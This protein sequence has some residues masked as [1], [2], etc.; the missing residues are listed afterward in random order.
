MKT[1]KIGCIC[2]KY[3][4]LQYLFCKNPRKNQL[5]HGKYL[6]L[7]I[8]H[9]IPA[10]GFTSFSQLFYWHLKFADWF[11]RSHVKEIRKYTK[12]STVTLCEGKYIKMYVYFSMSPSCTLETNYKRLEDKMNNRFAR[13][14]QKIWQLQC[15]NFQKNVHLAHI[16]VCVL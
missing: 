16:L 6:L 9:S 5:R 13:S 11:K 10:V 4:F 2:K 15:L 12:I 8:S 1:W 7:I 3:E 14:S